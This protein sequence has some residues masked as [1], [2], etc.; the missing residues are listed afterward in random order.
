MEFNSIDWHDVV[1]KSITIDR[2]EAGYNDAII[3]DIE[4]QDDRL[5][6]I[7][8][9][10]VYHGIFSMNFGVRA[11]EC[12]IEASESSELDDSFKK[13]WEKLLD[14]FSAFKTYEL[15]TASTNSSFKIIAKEVHIS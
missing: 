13:T 8:F 7:K 2:N 10:E 15:R 5:G 3:F 9:S 11:D 6:R 4:W 12:I 14:D 1:I